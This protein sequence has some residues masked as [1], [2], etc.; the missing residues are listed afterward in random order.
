MTQPLGIYLHIP[1]C[2]AKCS[3][4]AFVS[5]PD[6]EEFHAPYV[7]ALCKEIVAAGGDFNLRGKP[8][9]T[10]FFGGGT[11]TVLGA[12]EL[13]KIL[14]AV[15]MTFP[16]T[17]DAEV[18]VEANPGTLGQRELRELKAAGFNRLS[19]G[20]QSLDDKVLAAAGRIHT[21][22]QAMEI[23]RE[24]RRTGFENISL[25]LMYGL[26]G[27][28]LASWRETMACAIALHPEHVS[29]YGLKLEEGTPLSTAVRAG[30]IALPEE[31]AEEAMYDELNSF[32]PE[33]GYM[34]YEISNFALPGRE[35]R[36]NL[37]YWHWRPYRGFGVAAHSFIGS[38]RF[39]NTENLSEYL[40]IMQAGKS[41]EKFREKANLGIAMAEYTFLVLRTTAGLDIDDFASVFDCD[42]QKH[43]ASPLAKLKKMGLIYCDDRT[44]R[45]TSL[46]MKL[47]N[48]VFAEFLP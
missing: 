45:L 5:Q 18:T 26:P 21:A 29:A 34:R 48:Q 46:G 33:R 41:P 31:E 3:Y 17:T 32:L 36:H 13:A 8:V 37:K 4:C 12:V 11:P 43:F 35:C 24:A 14:E 47:G 28:S 7:A 6:A 27:Q 10:V 19:I 1:F 22:A 15:Q 44:V 38:E 9:D 42:F 30:R 40:Q 2:L 16:L 20:V 39:A 25:D 23:F